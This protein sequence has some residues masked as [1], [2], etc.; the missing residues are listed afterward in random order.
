MP[1][2]KKKKLDKNKSK[3]YK[4]DILKKYDW[5]TYINEGDLV[6]DMS[7]HIQYNAPN[8]YM[9]YL[10]LSAA[11]K[12]QKGQI[13]HHAV[14]S[15]EA[16]NGDNV[17]SFVIAGSGS[18]QWNKMNKNF[19]G[20]NEVLDKQKYVDGKT[21]NKESSDILKELGDK[22]HVSNVNPED[23]EELVN[24]LL[25]REYGK[26][27]Y[28][29]N[30]GKAVPANHPDAK[31]LSGFREKKN[32]THTK[33]NLSG[34][35]AMGGSSN[36]GDYSIENLEKYVV[37][38]AD[39][40][41]KSKSDQLKA[42]GQIKPIHIHIKGHSRGGVAANESATL[43]NQMVATKYPELKPYVDF[44]LAL[45]D[46]VPGFNSYREHAVVDHT[47]GEIN[48]PNGKGKG[49]NSEPNSKNNVSVI[50]SMISNDDFAHR[51][52]FA[53][54]EVKGA[55]RVIMTGKNHD[56][57]IYD[58][59]GT[60]KAGFVYTGNG[61]TYRGTGISQLPE[62]IFFCDEKN[63]LAKV[64]N[65]KQAQDI[66]ES[67][68]N[69]QGK[70]TRFFQK[71]RE[72]LMGRVFKD[73]FSRKA[74]V[75]DFEK[76]NRAHNNRVEA[77]N[78]LMENIERSNKPNA[79]AIDTE[80]AYRGRIA[81]MLVNRIA[82][83]KKVAIDRSKNIDLVMADPSFKL[84]CSGLKSEDIEALTNDYDAKKIDQLIDQY[85]TI[86]GDKKQSDP[87]RLLEAR[88]N[89]IAAAETVDPLVFAKL[90]NDG[91]APDKILSPVILG[92][93]KQQAMQAIEQMKLSAEGKA[94]INKMLVES[95]AKIHENM[96]RIQANMGDKSDTFLTDLTVGTVTTG[97][98]LGRLAAE[99]KNQGIEAA[100]KELATK[101]KDCGKFY[102]KLI[103][104]EKE[105]LYGSPEPELQENVKDNS[106]DGP[107]VLS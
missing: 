48:T 49:L 30:E 57:G 85:T 62:G 86:K 1:L 73:H 45:Y 69:T 90:V 87:E 91:F 40:W 67:A 46:P 35:L 102:E 19:S 61:E 89:K 103:D 93:E 92:K 14:A 5:S 59:E 82:E 76:G 99:F 50:Y 88:V 3:T 105:K 72:K 22:Y 96:S 71:F 44:E 17:L 58:V 70:I 15:R 52:F 37:N 38:Y 9:G 51:H 23:D 39:N 83:T 33:V 36:S 54:Q 65:A 10:N 7:T 95:T 31:L 64:K 20:Y 56:V 97:Q 18:V 55:N 41:L 43:I 98:M 60:H 74:E 80:G 29:D 53:P 101:A 21:I 24:D 2:F 12:E 25:T 63:R 68:L 77:I 66:M 106:K 8:S 13:A 79:R 26:A 4:L 94:Q 27:Q 107:Q 75:K 84:M 6:Q 78:G 34:P 81:D 104:A 100:N 28:V 47:S 42:G 16:E 32:G 11:E